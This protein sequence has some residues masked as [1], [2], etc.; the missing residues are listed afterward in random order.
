MIATFVTELRRLTINCDFGNFLDDTLGDRLVCR[1]Q[2]EQTQRKLLSEKHL[3]LVKALDIA[4]E[5]EPADSRSR[6]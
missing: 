6:R 1:R 2:N 5:M 4:Q 3:S